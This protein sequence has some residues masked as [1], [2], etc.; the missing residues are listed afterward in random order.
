M[1]PARKSAY[2]ALMATAIIWGF[3]PPIIKYTLGFIT[4]TSFLF[5]RF[6][7]AGL[8]LTPLFFIKL[9]KAKLTSKEIIKYFWLGLLGTPVTL[10]L[11]F[12]GIS[13]TT[14]IDA[15]VIAITSPIL[16]ILGGAFLLKESVNEN[17]KIGIGLTIVGT[18]AVI[19][20]PF[21]ETNFDFGHHIWGNVLVFCGAITWAGFTLIAKKQKLDPFIL[22]AFSFL[23]GTLSM[24]PFFLW[25]RFFL[26][27]HFPLLISSD[28][29]IFSIPLQALFG[30][31]YMAILG[32]VVAYFAYI[33]GLAK[34]EASEAV[35]FTYLQPVF[36]I[37]AAAIF[38]GEKITFPF[39]IGASFIGIGLFVCEKR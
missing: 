13:Q 17:E 19:L 24:L 3:A 39:L 38:L 33:D 2:F 8:I 21:L 4:P 34:I 20:Q 36:A 28:R 35:I 16:V 32:S 14:A 26:N 25:E 12:A 22:T 23:T 31:F 10:Y 1:T 18:L 37:P 27:A 9:K 15:S 11:L 30:I 6:L 5:Y 29:F 7:I